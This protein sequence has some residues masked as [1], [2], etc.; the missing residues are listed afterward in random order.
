MGCIIMPKDANTIRKDRFK[1]F[2]IWA[3]GSTP[4]P[5]DITTMNKWNVL[6]GDLYL[7]SS[8]EMRDISLEKMIAIYNTRRKKVDK[9]IKKV[10]KD[11]AKDDKP[12]A[13]KDIKKLMKMDK[14]QDKKVEKC[15]M[16]M[17]S[18]KK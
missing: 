12:K 8:D 3:F 7:A 15:D 4:Q 11:V 10:A 17:K 14:V 6:H 1:Q 18:K 16:K 9:Q 2:E 13:K 5:Y